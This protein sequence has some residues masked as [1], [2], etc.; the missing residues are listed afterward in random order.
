MKEEIIIQNISREDVDEII[1][2]G[3]STPELHVQSEK[4]MYYSKEALASFITS[5]TDIHL[6]AKVN[7]KIAGYRLATFNPYLKEAYLL[8]MVVK[9]EFRRKGIA[10][11]LYK[12]TFEILEAKGCQWMWTLVKE[13]NTL[14]QQILKKKGFQKGSKF[15]FYHK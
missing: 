11:E 15:Y 14:M 6:V 12:K 1:R 10:S 2:L 7:N 5:P 4:P 9:P 8:D 3:L 13:D